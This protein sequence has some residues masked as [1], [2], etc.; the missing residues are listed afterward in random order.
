MGSHM[1]QGL[2]WSKGFAPAL[3]PADI[4]GVSDAN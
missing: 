3:F 1:Q 2:S 4:S